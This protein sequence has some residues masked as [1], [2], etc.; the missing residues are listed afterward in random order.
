MIGFDTNVFIYACDK[1]ELFRQQTALDL[2][3]ATTDGVMLWRVA[4]EFIAASRKL[5]GQGL[6]PAKAW[7]RLAEFI[8]VLPLVIPSAAV[9]TRARALHV[10]SQWSS[11]DALITA[12]CLEAGV[13][14][15][16]SEDLPGRLPPPPL[17]II[18]PFA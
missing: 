9:L 15:L 2:I 1:S 13:T 5:A 14:R 3:D 10:D 12:A 16:Y 11:W 17:E 7:D 6:T 4:C 18:N 8:Q